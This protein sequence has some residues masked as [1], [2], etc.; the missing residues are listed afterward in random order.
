M[1]FNPVV[2]GGGN[3]SYSLT[4]HFVVD[5]APATAQAGEFVHCSFSGPTAG[6]EIIT[7]YPAICSASSSFSTARARAEAAAEMRNAPADD[8]Y[9]R[10]CGRELS[11]ILGLETDT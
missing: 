10:Q 4:N 5:G 1:I 7:I 11:E 8:E 6:Q 2:V 3:R 9:L